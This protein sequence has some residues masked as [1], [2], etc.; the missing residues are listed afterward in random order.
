M[1][2]QVSL[3]FVL[4][5]MLSV[6][7][8]AQSSIFIASTG[9]TPAPA[10]AA[11]GQNVPLQV[12]GWQFVYSQMFKWT[13]SQ[14]T[15][16]GTFSGPV[17]AQNGWLANP[18][19]GSARFDYMAGSSDDTLAI[20]ACN[21]VSASTYNCNG[22]IVLDASNNV[23]SN[24]AKWMLHRVTVSS[25]SSTSGT[26]CT[27]NWQ[28]TAFSTC[29]SGTQTRTCTYANNCGTIA[30]KPPVSQGCASAPVISPVKLIMTANKY[31][32]GVMG[33]AQ[34]VSCD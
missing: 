6:P 23:V 5:L 32:P 29:A 1:K 14:W 17:A 21:Q 11:P 8:F 18:A 31:T 26:T 25:G 2:K 33:A 34:A 22:N 12:S 15:S 16:V 10:S 13:G 28:C 27:P 19:G 24:S 9:V 7:V 4:A 30:G 20:F 3:L